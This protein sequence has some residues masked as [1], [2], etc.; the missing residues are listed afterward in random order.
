[1]VLRHHAHNVGADALGSV[2]GFDFASLIPGIGSIASAFFGG[3]KQEAPKPDPD[4]A[5]RQAVE[6]ALAEERA[7]REAE[8]ART[9]RNAAIGIAVGAGVIGLGVATW[10]IARRT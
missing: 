7:R 5:A 10:A 8:K 9:Q 1:M 6:R 4:A 2:V 3:S